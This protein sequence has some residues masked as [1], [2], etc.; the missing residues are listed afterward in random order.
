MKPARFAL[1]AGSAWELARFALLLSAT[2]R[3]ADGQV[4]RLAPLLVPL[5]APGLVMAAGLVA[6]ASLGQVRAGLLPL[7][8]TGKLLEAFSALSAL[9]AAFVVGAPAQIM[10]VVLLAVT[11]A[12]DL[13]FFLLLLRG[14]RG[15]ASESGPRG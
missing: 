15:S 14:D 11:A 9:A 13:V 7:L 3:L 2:A 1:L 8:R 6:S 12:L 5:A 4:A 10:L